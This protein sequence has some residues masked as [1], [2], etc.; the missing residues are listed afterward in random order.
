MEARRD[1]MSGD[2][3]IVGG[4]L[5]G[6]GIQYAVNVAPRRRRKTQENSDE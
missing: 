5:A 4:L 2:V 6:L 1:R 3:L